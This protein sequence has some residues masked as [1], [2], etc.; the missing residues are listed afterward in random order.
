MRH[1]LS[2]NIN[3]GN[4]RRIRGRSSTISTRIISRSRGSLSMSATTLWRANLMNMA[5]KL[6]S[7]M[8]MAGKLTMAL[9]I[10]EMML[11]TRRHQEEQSFPPRSLKRAR[12]L[13]MTGQCLQRPAAPLINLRSKLMKSLKERSSS[14]SLSSK[15]T[16]VRHPLTTV[17]RLRFS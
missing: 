10:M 9:K 12:T 8:T 11:N 14:L 15:L 4:M 5:V 7:S 13:P 2:S 6:T 17:R 3:Q 1:L 16:K